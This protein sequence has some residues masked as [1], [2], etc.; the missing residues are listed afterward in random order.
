MVKTG[1]TLL[2]VA[3]LISEYQYSEGI[4]AEKAKSELIAI[5][6]YISKILVASSKEEN[7]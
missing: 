4:S 3:E 6:D 2:K 1:E 5:R 7:K